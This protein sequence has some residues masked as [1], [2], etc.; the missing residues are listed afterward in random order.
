VVTSL[1]SHHRCQDVLNSG[2]AFSIGSSAG[3][4]SSIF[5][6]RNLSVA[7][8]TCAKS[9]SEY[10]R[11]SSEPALNRSIARSDSFSASCAGRGLLTVVSC[12]QRNNEASLAENRI[13]HPAWTARASRRQSHSRYSVGVVLYVQRRRTLRMN[14][15]RHCEVAPK[16]TLQRLSVIPSR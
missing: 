6:A 13:S 12:C 5:R 7:R 16:L 1:S 4:I 9:S 14:G 2:D 3:G 15:Q 11:T 8:W 10:E